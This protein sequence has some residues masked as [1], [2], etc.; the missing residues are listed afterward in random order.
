MA[1]LIKL[2]EETLAN[3]N[4]IESLEEQKKAL[5]TIASFMVNMNT[6]AKRA[7]AELEVAIDRRSQESKKC[8]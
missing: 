3:I 8:A 6:E 7:S 1:A 5:M 2:Y 4:S